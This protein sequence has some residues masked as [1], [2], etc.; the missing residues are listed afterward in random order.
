MILGEKDELM[1]IEH[2][3]ELAKR[4][5]VPEKNL[6][7]TDQGHFSGYFSLIA[8]PGPFKAFAMQLKAL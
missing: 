8:R 6:T 7:V 1:P 4:W 3:L 2:G 5:K